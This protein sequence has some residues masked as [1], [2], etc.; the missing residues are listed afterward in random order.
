MSERSRKNMASI[1]GWERNN[2]TE[3]R[4]CLGKLNG[5]LEEFVF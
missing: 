5:F 4:L 3:I 2:N 1:V